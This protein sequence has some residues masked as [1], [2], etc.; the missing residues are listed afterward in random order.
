L[1]SIPFTKVLGF[2][3]FHVTYKNLGIGAAEHSCGDVK[4]MKSGKQAH[5]GS[6]ATEK[7]STIFGAASMESAQIKRDSF[8]T[9][10]SVVTTWGQADIDYD[11]GLEKWGIEIP[12]PSRGHHCEPVLCL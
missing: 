11:L 5:L 8:P 9:D 6:S 4:K 2:V 10:K 12:L 3:A 7:Q 1:Y